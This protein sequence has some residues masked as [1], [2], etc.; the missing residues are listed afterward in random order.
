MVVCLIVMVTDGNYLMFT[1]CE[2]VLF[3][4]SVSVR[5]LVLVVSD[6]K[7]SVYDCICYC[8]GH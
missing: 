1:I 2:V 7:L 8:Q 3:I 6:V 5:R 4:Q